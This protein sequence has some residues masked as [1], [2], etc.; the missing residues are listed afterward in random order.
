M[1]TLLHRLF[2]K[3]KLNYT[4]AKQTLCNIAQEQYNPAQIAAFLAVFQLRGIELE[5]L[6]GFRDALL[7]LCI[8]VDLSD[9]DCIDVC[10]TGGDGKNTFNVSTLSAFVIAG[11]GYKV[12]KHGNYGVSSVCGSSNVLEY[13]GYQFTN[14]SD[15]L[16]QQLERANICFLHAPL[17]HPAMKSVA[18][19]RQQLGVKTFFNMLGP[20]VNPAQPQ[21]QLVGV[22]DLKL[23]RLYNYL[24]QQGNKQYAIIHA[25]DG[26]D[27]VS[28]TG[29]F[30]L[31]T[32][33]QEQIL[34]PQALNLPQYKAQDLFGG[35]TIKEAA[36]IF[37]QVLQGNGT[38]AQQDV[39]ACNAGIAIQR[40]EPN[41]S[42][43]DCI[44]KAK[45]TLAKG[46]AYQAF[47]SLTMKKASIIN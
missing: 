17:F 21:R 2:N 26:Y 32:N 4:E 42:L 39:V 35:N 1:K 5:E 10:G 9:F 22:F 23:Q 34:S 40:F 27:E 18:P 12:A 31:V 6:K 8:P 43:I 3:E 28:L 41:L 38:T 13:L 25:L 46:A 15:Q 19:I 20:M 45:E 37:M 30:K 24:Y 36:D 33:E 16:Q 29:N 47:K 7:E 44:A 11:A 14:N